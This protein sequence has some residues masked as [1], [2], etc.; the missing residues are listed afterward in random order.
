VF[1]ITGTGGTDHYPSNLSIEETVLVT[2]L[3]LF[4]ALIWTQV[5]ATF[6][7]VATNSHPGLTQ[8]RH[9]LDNLTEF[10][11]FNNLPVE[12]ARRMREFLQHQ[13][14]HHLREYATKVLPHLSTAL[15]IEAILHCH[16]HWL[17]S[18]WFLK[19][20]EKICCVRIAMSMSSMVIAPGEVAPHRK[21]YVTIR[22]CVLFGGK[23]LSSGTVWGDDVL[24]TDRRYFLPFL[25]RA[26]SYTDVLS[27][28][29][30]KFHRVLAS[31]PESAEK[32]R[33]FTIL[34]ALKRHMI[35]DHRR[36]KGVRHFAL[37]GTSNDTGDFLDQMMDR[38]EGLAVRQLK[39]TE[40]EQLRRKNQLESIL[41][42]VSL[43]SRMAVKLPNAAL[44]K[45]S[46][47]AQGGAS[48]DTTETQL[49]KD[50]R[51]LKADMK[52][53]KDNIMLMKAMMEKLMA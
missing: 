19:N 35:A 3:V 46:G 20:V 33:R 13:K 14:D 4:G 21:L 11:A 34:L 30:E 27:L 53:V 26:M 39:L 40:K 42:A 38:V 25:A 1:V 50:V 24:L 51:G 48:D 36:R 8:Y 22:G 32:I 10:V 15:Q 31:F 28:S 43:Q 45:A 49:Q 12:M 29:H 16:R 6:C 17:E 5:L 52:L 47:A 2:A 7:D 18:I 23:I 41:M 44:Q 9:Q 37:H